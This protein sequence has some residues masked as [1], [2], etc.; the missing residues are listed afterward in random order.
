MRKLGLSVVICLALIGIFCLVG[1]DD[2]MGGGWVWDF[3]NRSS[4]TLRF[5][6][7]GQTW[8]GFDLAP[9]QDR[10]I[11]LYENGGA[12]SYYYSHQDMVRHE[13]DGNDIIFY[14]R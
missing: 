7:N 1:C 2:T 14:N 4:Y 13:T 12:I 3:K 10:Q 8:L 5:D 9:G 11:T 6:P